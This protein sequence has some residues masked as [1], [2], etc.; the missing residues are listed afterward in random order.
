MMEIFETILPNGTSGVCV[1]TGYSGCG[2]TSLVRDALVKM[3]DK[4]ALIASAKFD[5]FTKDVPYTAIVCSL[6]QN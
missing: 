2:K 5:Q 3:R 4:G 1:V 6:I